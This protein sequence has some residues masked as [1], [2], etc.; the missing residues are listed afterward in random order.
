[1]V[2]S[3]FIN[4]YLKTSNRRQISQTAT[5]TAA[6][7]EKRFDCCRFDFLLFIIFADNPALIRVIPL[8]RTALINLNAVLETG[9][10]LMPESK[11]D[12]FEA[13]N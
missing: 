3:Q 1:V 6:G 5:S 13:Y 8:S 12:F 11:T 7:F 10:H 4:Q 9:Q 2:K